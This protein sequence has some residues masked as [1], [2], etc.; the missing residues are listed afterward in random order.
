MHQNAQNTTPATVSRLLDAKIA[1]DRRAR[2]E[3]AR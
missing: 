2:R 3:V 1:P